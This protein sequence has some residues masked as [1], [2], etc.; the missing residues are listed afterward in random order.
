M[1]FCT[2]IK[3]RS[4]ELVVPILTMFSI[5]A[6]RLFPTVNQIVSGISHIRFGRPIVSL[7]Y[8]DLVGAENHH[9]DIEINNLDEES[10]FMKY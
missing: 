7:L 9:F 8:K 1:W 2:H 10:P 6:I 5:A 3:K 4:L